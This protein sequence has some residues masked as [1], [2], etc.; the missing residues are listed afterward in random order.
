VNII[1]FGDSIMHGSSFA[2]GDRWPTILANKL[3]QWRP[4]KYKVYNRGINGHTTTQGVDRVNTD[5][6]PYLPGL[7]LVEFGF[8]DAFVRDWLK[9]AQVGLE[10][11]KI[12]MREFH[13]LARVHK[14][15]C[16]YII[17]H[18]IPARK[19]KQ[20]DGSSYVASV[21]RYSQAAR[22]VA[23]QLKAPMIDLPAIM[24]KQRVALK[25]FLGDDGLHLTVEGNHT[26]ADMVFEQLK[27]IL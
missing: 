5:V 23:R 9:I 12:N 11:Y 10:Q 14:S 6:I 19:N 25:Q 7:L 17:N 24:K 8:N 18:T 4:G 13:R 20:G 16:V 26:Y 1:C 2:E 15:R 27:E 22:D 3:E 21:K